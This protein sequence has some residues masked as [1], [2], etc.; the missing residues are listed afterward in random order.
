M[1]TPAL[2]PFPTAGRFGLLAV[3]KRVAEIERNPRQ[4]T[5][6]QQDPRTKT[7]SLRRI[8]HGPVSMFHRRIA[9]SSLSDRRNRV[10]FVAFPVP[11][12]PIRFCERRKNDVFTAE[13]NV[14]HDLEPRQERLCRPTRKCTKKHHPRCKTT[15]TSRRRM[16]SCRERTAI[17]T[18]FSPLT[19]ASKSPNHDCF[20]RKTAFR[21]GW[22][23]CLPILLLASQLALDGHKG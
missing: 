19:R 7:L 23:C 11:S 5:V 9:Q 13:A 16:G 22:L 3:G 12:R 1:P 14:R 18:F 20:P 10:V 15:R 4:T 6:A 8:D 21:G 17:S 2:N